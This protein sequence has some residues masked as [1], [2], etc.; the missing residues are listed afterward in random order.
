MT[1]I[2]H[3]NRQHIAIWLQAARDAVQAGYA[4]WSGVFEDAIKLDNTQ[5]ATIERIR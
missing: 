1:K 4:V 2:I 5:G 3:V